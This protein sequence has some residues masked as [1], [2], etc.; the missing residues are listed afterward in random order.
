MH[1]DDINSFSEGKNKK[2][3][4]FRKMIIQANFNKNIISYKDNIS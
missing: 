1:Y 4:N 3:K 2:Q